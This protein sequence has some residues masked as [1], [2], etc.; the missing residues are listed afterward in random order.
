[1][2]ECAD[3]QDVVSECTQGDA[4]HSTTEICDDLQAGGRL[5]EVSRPAESSR[6]AFISLILLLLD[7][8]TVGQLFLL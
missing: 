7:R 8:R 4:Q 3:R 2:C 1:M 6:A 5:A